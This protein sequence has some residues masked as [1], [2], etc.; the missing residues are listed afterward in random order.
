MKP[1]YYLIVLTNVF[2]A[3]AAGV[4]PVAEEVV[5]SVAYCGGYSKKGCDNYCQNQGYKC[6]E[7]T[8]SKCQCKHKG[9]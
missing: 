7:C 3:A 6:Y 5:D 2:L 8:S 1:A 9:C 4:T